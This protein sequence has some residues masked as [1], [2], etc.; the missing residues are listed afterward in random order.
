MELAFALTLPWRQ[1]IR[2]GPGGTDVAVWFD[3]A[4]YRGQGT[5]L[6]RIP[7]YKRHDTDTGSP[8]VQIARLTAR[9][10]QLTEHLKANKKDFAC[11]RG[12]K[13]ILGRRKR[14]L[15]YL[16]KHDR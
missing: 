12:L 3:S 9:V 6:S 8:E 14:L 1:Y 15:K 16:Y 7:Q 4:R 13:Q 2:Q 10:T 5:D 11:E